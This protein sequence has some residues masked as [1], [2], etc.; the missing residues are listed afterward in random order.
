MPHWPACW[1]LWRPVPTLPPE[2][3]QG[4]SRSRSFLGD[5]FM[6]SGPASA[7]GWLLAP[8][9]MHGTFACTGSPQLCRQWGLSGHSTQP[10]GVGAGRRSPLV[11]SPSHG[12]P[13]Y[14]RG[15]GWSWPPADWPW[16]RACMHLLATRGGPQSLDQSP[17]P[18]LRDRVAAAWAPGP[19]S[20]AE[21]GVGGGLCSGPGAVVSVLARLGVQF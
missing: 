16:G 18:I 5:S 20:E 14:G 4:L 9:P 3:S 19:C 13:A 12:D 6:T 11:R 2:S 15:A 10:A 17:G 7:R 21:G 1:G 8:A